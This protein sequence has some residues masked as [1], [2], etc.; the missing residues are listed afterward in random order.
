[1]L[2]RDRMKIAIDID[3][4]LHHYWDCF[5]KAA[6]ERFGIDLPYEEQLDWG[7]YG[8]RPEQLKA[9]I[10]ATHKP[11]EILAAKPYAGAVEVV[12][13]WREQGHEIHVLSHREAT[14]Q[15]P[16]EHWLQEIGL[17]YDAL[18]CCVDKVAG[19]VALGVELLIDDSPV[20]LQG[21]LDE[22][23]AV[24][25]IVHPWNRE[26]VEME[27]IVAAPD[28]PSLAERLAPMLDAQPT[29]G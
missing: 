19:C 26:L 5:A 18:D 16:T 14:C 20:N 13:R 24:A 22:G 11:H 8:L 27:G 29:P 21:A 25:T 7:A 6:R 17:P 2:P 1:M 3:S 28:W 9:V 15:G 10:A 23:M 4:T 12:R